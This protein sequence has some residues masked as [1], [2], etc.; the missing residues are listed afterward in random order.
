VEQRGM[1]PC[2]QHQQQAFTFGDRQHGLPISAQRFPATGS[3]WREHRPASKPAK[4]KS[5]RAP[6]VSWKTPAACPDQHWWTG[7]RGSI[8]SACAHV[9]PLSCSS[10]YTL[11]SRWRCCW[12]SMGRHTRRLSPPYSISN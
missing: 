12:S 3:T 11:W 10:H 4:R 1:P 5:P 6:A 2:W 9:P 8:L 7:A